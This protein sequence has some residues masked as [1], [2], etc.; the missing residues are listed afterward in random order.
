MD[1]M[2]GLTQDFQGLTI[3]QPQ[4]NGAQNAQPIRRSESV[5]SIGRALPSGATVVTMGRYTVTV[6]QPVQQNNS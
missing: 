2:Q 6:M 1:A 5:A 4:Q 3:A